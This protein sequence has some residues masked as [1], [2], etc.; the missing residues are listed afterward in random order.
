MADENKKDEQSVD[1][2]NA[3]NVASLSM[4]TIISALHQN[5]IKHSDAKSKGVRIA[6]S[7]IED[8]DGKAKLTSSGEHIISVMP[9]EGAE[10]KPL[11]KK[12]AIAILKSYVQWFVGPDLANKVN[13]STVK[14]LSES[15]DQP[16]K[17]EEKKEEKKPENKEEDLEDNNDFVAESNGLHKNI[18]S[19]K[20]FINE[21]NSF[22][23]D[24]NLPE[25]KNDDKSDETPK[26]DDAKNNEKDDGITS[27]VGYYIPYSLKVEGL[28]QTALKDAMKKFAKTF[29]DDVTIT[30]SG[31]F[32]GG[33]SFTIKDIKDKFK[34][35]FGSIDPDELV[36]NIRKEINDIRHPDTDQPTI[37]IRDKSTLIRDLG[38][39]INGK[40][41]QLIDSANYSVWIQLQEQDP[42]KPIFNRTVVADIVTGSVKGLFKKF[43]NKISKDDVI[44]I[45]DYQDI[46]GDAKK[47]Q[48]LNHEVPTPNQ[49]ND[50]IAKADSYNNAMKKLEVL[51]DKIDK[52]TTLIN[53]SPFAS[54]MLSVWKKF[55]QNVDK[56]QRSKDTTKISGDDEQKQKTLNLFFG[57][58]KDAYEKKYNELKKNEDLYEA[59]C[60]AKA[61]SKLYG[62]L[63]D[64]KKL[65]IESLFED[66]EQDNGKEDNDDFTSAVKE[67]SGII[68]KDVDGFKPNDVTVS[69]KSKL[70]SMLKIYED[71][72]KLE[73]KFGEFNNGIA[74]DFSG[75]VSSNT[76]AESSIRD[77]IMSLL[78]EEDN[79]ADN[80]NENNK[81]SSYPSEESVRK[82]FGL[83]CKKAGL[84]E[85]Q[86]GQVY[87]FR[88]NDALSESK[89]D[90]KKL[91]KK[92]LNI[93][94]DAL[95]SKIESNILKLGSKKNIGNAIKIGT[96]DDISKFLNEYKI[97]S[98]DISNLKDKG[99]Y[100][101]VAFV[102]NPRKVKTKDGTIADCKGT[103]NNEK[104]TISAFKEQL[105][106]T[107][108]QDEYQVEINDDAVDYVKKST[109]DVGKSETTLYWKNLKELNKRAADP[110]WRAD[111]HVIAMAFNVKQ[112]EKPR[113]GGSKDNPEAYLMPFGGKAINDEPNVDVDTNDIDL[114]ENKGT[115]LYIIP[116]PGLRYKD[117]EY[118]AGA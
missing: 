48:K 96:Y 29:F 8:K 10:Q 23:S 11:D 99:E 53:M 12:T 50:A 110:R 15:P 6:N 35:T 98:S 86:H 76:I 24:E 27:K 42:K 92:Q 84:D 47:L 91:D 41:K 85:N 22:D 79:P 114:G 100:C 109:L 74:V 4:P 103:Q 20:Q 72:G 13:D 78:F 45:K 2:S 90:A 33:D 94:Q 82:A 30:A 112:Q 14:E 34:D 46:H 71:A 36:S 66:E 7:A 62:S 9:I 81:K 55:K 54:T 26:E 107:F 18:I 83:L 95:K 28:K 111:C 3:Q 73:Q 60:K 77:E 70:I 65:I 63:V 57:K 43:K 105:T 80:S 56:D 115:D 75:N 117:K 38:K 68:F 32:G 102:K 93:F 87:A 116:M 58:F 106:N 5:A 101:A 52:Q 49:V 39:A 104:F 51:F 40:Q 118:D 89:D 17:K 37:S 61:M 69:N 97:Y 21:A 1:N 88:Y 44:Y 59:I 31:L 113:P 25:E 108:D 64:M 16:K 67:H 19:F